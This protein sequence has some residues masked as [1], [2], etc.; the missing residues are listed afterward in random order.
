MY[1]STRVSPPELT[2]C[3]SA[4]NDTECH[5]LRLPA[6]LRIM[7]YGHVLGAHPIQ[8]YEVDEC[9]AC[10]EADRIEFTLHY[11]GNLAMLLTCRQVY[12]EAKLLPF[13]LNTFTVGFSDIL[14][15]HDSELRWWQINAIT[16]LHIEC[17]VFIAKMEIRETMVKKGQLAQLGYSAR[18]FVL[19]LEM[20][21]RLPV[22][23]RLCVVWRHIRAYEGESCNAQQ[24]LLEQYRSGMIDREDV[25]VSVKMVEEEFP[26]NYF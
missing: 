20:L 3:S 12:T 24:L 14:Q 7:I 4:R 21:G 6:E 10:W 2:R 25:E 26:S 19:I 17:L 8:G 15:L 18:D 1:S 9:R 23:K 13:K 22:L 5:L 16:E 11:E